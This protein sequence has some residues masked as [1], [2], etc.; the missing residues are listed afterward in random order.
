MYLLHY[1]PATGVT[2]L[3]ARS[4]TQSHPSTQGRTSQLRQ[5][6]PG[7][8]PVVALTRLCSQACLASIPAA[9]G[10]SDSFPCPRCCHSPGKE[11]AEGLPITRTGTETTKFCLKHF[12][13]STHKDFLSVHS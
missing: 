3:S 9:Q 5:M 10:G 1:L 7:L 6:S 4:E 12:W 2:N 13:K 8:V 11:Q